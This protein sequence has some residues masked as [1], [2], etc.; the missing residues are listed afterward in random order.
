M[1][2]MNAAGDMINSGAV[3]RECV[4]RQFSDSNQSIINSWTYGIENAFHER[5][6]QAKTMAPCPTTASF[7]RSACMCM[8]AHSLQGYKAESLCREEG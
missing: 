4:W 5:L 1:T 3:Q 8:G 2:W 6:L 7:G